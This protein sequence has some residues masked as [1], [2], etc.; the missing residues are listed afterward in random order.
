MATIFRHNSKSAIKC[1]LCGRAK[2]QFYPTN[3]GGESYRFCSGVHLQRAEANYEQNK[4]IRFIEPGEDDPRIDF[5]QPE[6]Y[7]S[8]N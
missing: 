3:I 7:E 2:H 1:D 4:N 8:T 6:S 5:E